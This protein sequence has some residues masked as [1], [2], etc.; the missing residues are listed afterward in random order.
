MFIIYWIAEILLAI[1]GLAPLAG[2]GIGF[3]FQDKSVEAITKLATFEIDLYV[4]VI[5][6]N[7]QELISFL[8]ENRIYLVA[9]GALAI[10]L[11][12]VVNK[13]RKK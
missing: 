13:M 4:D 9:G 11:C 3:Y 7:G 8:I 10:V 2:G 12:F 5:K 1:G 6:V